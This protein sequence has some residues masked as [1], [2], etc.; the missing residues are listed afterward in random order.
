M[1]PSELRKHLPTYADGEL[2]PALRE[3]IESL[4]ESDPASR[5]ELQRW[6]ALRHCAHRAIA[7]EPLP[8]G[9]A[10]LVRN[11]LAARRRPATGRILRLGLPGLAAAAAIV[12]AVT[13]WP[14]GAQATP[15]EAHGFADVYRTC[16]VAHRHDTFDVRD[17]VPADVMAQLREEAAFIC[18]VPDATKCGFHVDGACECFHGDEGIRVVHVYFRCNKDDT[19][20]I[21]AFATD[22]RVDMCSEGCQCPECAA[23][24]RHYHVAHDDDVTLLAW[25]D[26][27]RS[28]VVCSDMNEKTLV[29]MVDTMEIARPVASSHTDNLAS[30]LPK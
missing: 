10:E 21:S 2:E 11:R 1:N 27:D 18:N 15:V 20:V 30:L 26:D 19:K 6:Q 29:R 7:E 4:L 28:Y 3:R 24:R 22:R 9:L 23:G 8:A 14:R 25:T 12:L 17:K 5:A 16:A 13:F